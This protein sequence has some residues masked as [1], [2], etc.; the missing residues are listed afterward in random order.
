MNEIKGATVGVLDATM[1]DCLDL[2]LRRWYT[3]NL[4]VQTKHMAIKHT[5]ETY[6]K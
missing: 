3:S 5:C 6:K 4:L 1:D 2:G